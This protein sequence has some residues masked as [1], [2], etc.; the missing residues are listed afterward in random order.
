MN[1]ID[2][3]TNVSSM[4]GIQA[5]TVGHVIMLLIG[6][7]FIYLAIAKKFEP[8]ILLPLGFGA[9][10]ANLPLGDLLGHGLFHYLYFPV[11][12]ELFPLLIFIGVGALTDFGPLIAFPFSM[13]CGAAAQAGI[14]IVMIM[15]VALGF[16][17]PEAASIG[18][19]GGAD[20]P[21]AVFATMRM[22]PHLIGPVAAAAYSYMAL[23]PLI[24]PPIMRLL[25]TRKERETVMEQLR[26]VSRKEKILFPIVLTIIVGLVVPTAIP[27]IGCL[28]IGNLLRESGVTERLA[29]TAGNELINIVTILLSLTIGVTM[30]AENFLVVE[31]LKIM[32]L[33]LLA[34]AFGT[35]A[36]VIMGKI[37]YVLTKGKVNPL[38][39]SAG[40]SA[41]PM[42]AR[43]SQIEGQRANP[44]NFLL[45][46]AMGANVAGVIGTTV[47][48]GILIAL[49]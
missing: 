40:V 17:L 42:A 19:T 33:S 4:S 47:A 11:E 35:A 41:I 26:P 22:A 28:A 37:L 45:M 48:I 43:V 38:I 32:V 8:L 21:I 14:F 24:Q 49:T 1:L 20:G 46:H 13:L 9:I 6:S 2:M 30:A 34:F 29:K 36:G 23:V 15:G 39:G 7:L 25:T 12:H 44:N 16:T 10:L 27:L 31:T 18:S 3:L 5:L